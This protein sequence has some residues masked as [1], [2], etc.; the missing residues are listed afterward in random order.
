MKILSHGVTNSINLWVA[1]G[2][3]VPSTFGSGC[4]KHESL[5]VPGAT[6]HT[7]TMEDCTPMVIRTSSVVLLD[8]TRTLTPTMT[9]RTLPLNFRA[10]V[11]H[12]LC[13]FAVYALPF[14]TVICECSLFR[15]RR[16]ELRTPPALCV[17]GVYP[18]KFSRT[19]KNTS[20]IDW[21]AVLLAWLIDWFIV[22]LINWLIDWLI[23]W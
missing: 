23:D 14:L 8:S 11:A 12:V 18:Q 1:T 4:W 10:L 13:Y 5:R 6:S 9:P 21:K 2:F 20:V 22:W 17:M 19:I 15:G 16:L 3:G 7:H